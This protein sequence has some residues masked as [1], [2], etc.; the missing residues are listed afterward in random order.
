M[1]RAVCV[2]L[3]FCAVAF[4]EPEKKAPAPPPEP[5][6]EP[7]PTYDKKGDFMAYDKKDEGKK[8]WQTIEQEPVYEC[9]HGSTPTKD[10]GCVTTKE[11]KAK[12][13]CPHG[14]DKDGHKCT[15]KDSVAP[16]EVCDNGAKAH[17]GKCKLVEHV[18]ASAKC[19][20]HYK[21]HGHVCIPEKGEEPA[22][23]VCKGGY[24]MEKG[25]CVKTVETKP[26]YTCPKGHTL[27][28]KNCQ[29]T[30]HVAPVCKK[31]YT[32]SKNG[33]V[34]AVDHGAPHTS[35]PHGYK[36]DNK[37]GKHGATCV[38]EKH[39]DADEICEHGTKK[40]G[41]CITHETAPMQYECKKGYHMQGH[42]CVKVLEDKP[43]KRCPHGYKPVKS[44]GKGKE[45]HSHECIKEKGDKKPHEVCPKGTVLKG[46][47][48][49]S[50][51]V[52][53]AE[54]K[55]KKGHLV[56]GKCVSH[57]EHKKALTCEHGYVLRNGVCVL[58]KSEKAVETC[59]HG[60]ELKGH[61]C[62]SKVATKPTIVKKEMKTK[63]PQMTCPKGYKMSKKEGKHGA[64]CIKEKV[65]HASPSCP[66]GYTL[67]GHKCWTEHVVPATSKC[68][69]TTTK[70]GKCVK[71]QPTKSVP[72]CEKGY[73]L[74][75]HRCIKKI[76]VEV[77]AVP[78]HK[79]APRHDKKES[80]E[81]PVY[82]EHHEP[83]PSKK[84]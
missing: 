84:I 74:K 54:Y 3:L 65:E 13:S 41:K 44:S 22:K 11:V 18:A 17:N 81:T 46:H 55:C 40:G 31:G 4:A 73:S 49:V 9:P 60:Q 38:K 21:M 14:Y 57:S 52:K 69:G 79:K 33:C 39:V 68:D 2:A 83:A 27:H 16:Y 12:I 32:P 59:P 19:P 23:H 37:G 34:K 72:K 70:D 53:P 7:A 75:G 30:H 62:V 45:G 50:Q 58:H 82:H 8:E 63:G 66:K 71:Y 43:D 15:K 51:H 29:S 80:K 1:M 56:N 36:L 6:H 24:R 61:K 5:K 77:P 10:K 48:C 28:G 25:H 42:K 78:V 20:K 26:T 67:K 47:K 76:Q 35:C 64:T